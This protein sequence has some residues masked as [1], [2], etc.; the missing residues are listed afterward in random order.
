MFFFFF[1][2]RSLLLFVKYSLVFYLWLLLMPRCLE[3][4]MLII[5]KVW[6]LAN[7]MYVLDFYRNHLVCLSVCLFVS[8]HTLNHSGGFNKT[9]L[10]HIV[11]MCKM[12]DAF[13]WVQ[14]QWIILHCLSSEG[15][16]VVCV[17]LIKLGTHLL[18]W[19][20]SWFT[21]LGSV[22]YSVLF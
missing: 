3:Q 14:L 17:F 8:P 11:L 10:R 9:E 16:G 1:V 15:W 22:D 5:I 6:R 13:N 2:K 4:W 20:N 18:F 7:Y 19:R 12:E 21:F